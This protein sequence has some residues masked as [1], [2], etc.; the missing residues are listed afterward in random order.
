MR[1]KLNAQEIIDR[2]QR[3]ADE[4]RRRYFTG[5]VLGL[6]FVPIKLGKPRPAPDSQPVG[7]KEGKPKDSY[8]EYG[9]KGSIKLSYKWI[10]R[11][12]M[13]RML[14]A[15]DVE[16]Y[17]IEWGLMKEVIFHEQLHCLVH[18]K[19][20]QSPEQEGHSKWDEREGHSNWFLFY[21]HQLCLEHGIRLH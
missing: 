12:A 17:Q 2:V 14:A 11:K 21:V 16:E 18:R 1:R 8:G 7:S 3:I 19:H 20:G 13:C 5:P 15:A 4:I 10:S 9:L 6:E